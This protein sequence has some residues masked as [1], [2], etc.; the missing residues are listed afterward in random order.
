MYHS[1]QINSFGLFLELDDVSSTSN[2]TSLPPLIP[3][4][5]KA[6]YAPKVRIYAADLLAALRHHPFINNTLLTA[7]CDFQHLFKITTLWIRL[8]S[9]D[10]T[11]SS[12]GGET[13]SDVYERDIELR[14]A[15]VAE[16]LSMCVLH[17]LRTRLPEQRWDS[18]WNKQP[19]SEQAQKM[20]D[21]IRN[22]ARLRYDLII[23]DVLDKV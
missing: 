7:Q 14:P 13:S 20:D 5:P 1:V 8:K 3:L 4:L 19:K 17:R 10:A 23:E 6:Y 18:F 12:K 15:D 2:P 21:A 9:F 16:V 11:L 22:G